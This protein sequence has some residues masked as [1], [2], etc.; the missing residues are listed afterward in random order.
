MN[1][2]TDEWAEKSMMMM[3]M[4]IISAGTKENEM[5][6]RKRAQ[7]RRIGHSLGKGTWVSKKLIV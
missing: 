4:I 3:M 6:Q 5:C 1:E 2:R 7:S